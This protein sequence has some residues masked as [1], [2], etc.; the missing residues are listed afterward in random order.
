MGIRGLH[1]SE[2][3][4]KDVPIPAENV[5]GEIGQGLT[6]ALKTVDDARLGAAAMSI[7]MADRLLEL[8][9]EYTQ[10]T[11]RVGRPLS[12][13]QAIQWLLA[14]MGTEIYAARLMLYHAATQ[15]DQGRRIRLEAAMCK[16]FASEMTSRTVDRALGIFGNEG[17]LGGS[18][19]ER[20]CRDARVLRIFDGT[21][22]IQR[23]VIGR[24]MLKG[25]KPFTW[26]PQ[27]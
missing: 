12:D 16:V 6:L 18:A 8:S 10:R 19:V 9:I 11:S 3:N 25:E 26:E 20:I 1:K 15:R 14:D 2:V 13:G 22:E 5:L 23:N 17:Y 27:Q 4:F 24:A 7:G 21:S